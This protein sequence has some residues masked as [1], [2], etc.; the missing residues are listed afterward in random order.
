VVFVVAATGFALRP[1]VADLQARSGQVA[2]ANDEPLAAYGDF[3]EASSWLGHE[4]RYHQRQA[5]A[6][7]AAAAVEG[8]DPELRQTLLDEALIAYGNA[9]DRAPGDVT[10]RQAQAE[11]L[12]LAAEAAS[13][14]DVSIGH[15]DEAIAI[16]RDLQA[17]VEA[18]DDLRLGYGRALE[19]RADLVSGSEAE[20]DRELAS[21]QYEA[22]RSYLASRAEATVGLARLAVEAG[23]LRGARKLLVEARRESHGDERLDAAIDEIDRRIESGR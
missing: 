9:L 12:V 6:L 2:E 17:S 4:P 3:A 15:L 13:D 7:V 16:Y 1:V 14:T 18:P 21:E 10:L 11:T 20:R 23:D 22:A 5:A 19:V 8:T